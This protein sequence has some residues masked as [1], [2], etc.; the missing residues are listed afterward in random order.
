MR[1]PWLTPE[2]SYL[3]HFGAGG[4]NN[5]NYTRDRA[6]NRKEY[7]KQKRGL[8]LEYLRDETDMALNSVLEVD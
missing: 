3:E 7:L 2:I 4:I 1:L 5:D 8:I 6:V